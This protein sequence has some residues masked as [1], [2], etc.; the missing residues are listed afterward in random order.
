MSSCTQRRIVLLEAFYGG[1]HRQL[2]DT[3]ERIL[4]EKYSSPHG[5]TT[6]IEKICMTDK[7]WHWRMR[8]SAL[9]FSQ[10]INQD[11]TPVQ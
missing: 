6:R 8:T 11:A 7:K 10:H 3:L 9:Y 5:V 4:L 2:V 1:S